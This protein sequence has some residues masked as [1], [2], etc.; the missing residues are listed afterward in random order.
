LFP[1][2]TV[3]GDHRS[4]SRWE[5]DHKLP[6]PETHRRAFPRPA[7]R[8]LPNEGLEALVGGSGEVTGPADFAGGDDLVVRPDAAQ[9]TALAPE[10]TEGWDPVR[11]LPRGAVRLLH[12]RPGPELSAP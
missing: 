10:E 5:E 9:I 12:P 8:P 4:P 3:R 7:I 11:Q 2:E 1:G 6:I